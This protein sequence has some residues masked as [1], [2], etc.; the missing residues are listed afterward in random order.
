MNAAMTAIARLAS[1][2]LDA[3]DPGR[4]AEFYR[5]LLELENLFENEDFIALKGAGVFL[6]VQRVADHVPPDWPEGR[7]PKQMHLDLSVDDLDGAE[8]AALSLGA[9]RPDDQPNPDK[10]RVLIDPAGHPFCFTTL[11]PDV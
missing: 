6:T 5:G 3:A 1:V 11:I 10:W 7:V 2:S 4:L 8:R 9:T